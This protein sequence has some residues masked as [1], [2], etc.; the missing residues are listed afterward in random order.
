MTDFNLDNNTKKALF[1][2][3]SEEWIAA[4]MYEQM[5]LGCK[6][7]DRHYIDKLFNETAED[8][9]NDHYYKL[10]MFAS[11]FD[12]KIPCK[13]EDYKKYAAQDVVKQ[14]DSWKKDKDAK[15][16]I[17]QVI[18]AEEY[19]IISYNEVLNDEKI[20][21]NFKRLLLDMYYDEIEHLAQFKTLLLSFSYG[22]LLK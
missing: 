22:M 17:E 4:T 5:I 19:A 6:A 21:D 16:Y 10:V 13:I 8:E 20:D 12:V 14:F 18:L 11:Q 2:L 9:R 7:E 1:K 3:I 15:Y